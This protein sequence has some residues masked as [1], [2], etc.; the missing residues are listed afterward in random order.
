M[1]I[2]TNHLKAILYADNLLENSRNVEKDKCPTIQHFLYTCQRSR[3]DT[4]IPYGN[5]TPT[6]LKFTIR[7]GKPDDAKIFYQQI[8]MNEL[9]FFSFIFNANFDQNK[10]LKDYDD[11]MVVRGYV[12]DIKEDYAPA[13]SDATDQMLVEVTLLLSRITYVGK[14]DR[15]MQLEITNF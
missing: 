12:V 2:L 8:R 5:T 7:L 4:G 14:E 13:T 15:H 3:N 11:A 10:R 6:E 1:P 9:F